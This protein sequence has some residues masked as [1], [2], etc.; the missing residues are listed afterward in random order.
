MQSYL[1]ILFVNEMRCG[2]SC[3]VSG[4]M[5]KVLRGRCFIEFQCVSSYTQATLLNNLS[6]V[7]Y[8]VVFSAVTAVDKLLLCFSS[9]YGSMRLGSINNMAE[10]TKKDIGRVDPVNKGKNGGVRGASKCNI[11]KGKT[12]VEKDKVG[13]R[14]NEKTDS[15]ILK[16]LQ[17]IQSSQ[18]LYDSRMDSLCQRL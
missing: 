5:M 6:S 10:L 8:L 12:I 13:V 7:L 16:C 4:S 9:F 3:T 18:K 11:S 15:L 2:P 1:F 14:E 17:D